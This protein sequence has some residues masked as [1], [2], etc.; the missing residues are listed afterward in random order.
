[1]DFDGVQEILV[2]R[3]RNELDPECYYHNADHT[4]E[5]I[6][7]ARIL[8]GMEQCDRHTLQLIETAALFHDSGIL[9]RYEGHEAE[10]VMI[11]AEMLPDFGYE[12]EDIETVIRLIHSTHDS[13][14]PSTPEE[15]ILCDADLDALGREDFFV[16]SFRLKLEWEAKGIRRTGLREWFAFEAAFLEKH[17][18]YTAAAEKLHGDQKRKNLEAI[19]ELLA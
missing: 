16:Q 11:A 9:F 15:K 4:L 2:K 5:V 12:P 13:V 8:A 3:L 17:R 14:I 10:S 6:R 7:A 18:Y 19:R 1:M